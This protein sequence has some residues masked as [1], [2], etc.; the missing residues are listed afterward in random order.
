M[1]RLFKIM[2]TA[3]LV[4][5]DNQEVLRQAVFSGFVQRDVIVGRWRKLYGPKW[6]MLKIKTDLMKLVFKYIIT[7]TGAILFNESTPHAQVAQGFPKVYSAGFCVLNLS[8]LD[9]TI[10]CYGESTSLK[11][12]AIPKLDE[13]VVADL[14]EEVSQIKY[15][16]MMVKN[17]Y[18]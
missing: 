8:K 11:I 18:K 5:R 9:P 3:E 6:N 4:R 17:L 7:D 13:Q 2:N 15:F 10:H 14:F 16:G 1:P 12:K